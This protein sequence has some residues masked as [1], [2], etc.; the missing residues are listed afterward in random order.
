MPRL[1]AVWT[2]SFLDSSRMAARVTLATIASDETA[3]A[4]AGKVRCFTWSK[5]PTPL[6]IE[7]NHCS[8]T[9]KTRISTIA[10]TKAGSDAEI[11]VMTRTLESR[12]PGR[13]PDAMPRPTPMAM[14]RIDAYRTSPAVV[15]IRD[16]IRSETFS[17]RV[18]EIPRLPCSAL[19]S[20]Y[21]YWT[22]NG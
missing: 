18:I 19:V 10:A 8:C 11:A 5:N 4:T 14:I 17:R 20:Q 22:R 2:C 1:T 12:R 15:E 9:A 6:P 13:R 3:R 16:A 7:G 21:Q